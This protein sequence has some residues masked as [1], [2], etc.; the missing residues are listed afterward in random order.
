MKFGIRTP[1]LK[2]MIAARASPARIVRHTRG[3]TAP[4]G[5]G[6]LTNPKRAMYNRA[7]ERP[8]ASGPF[9]PHLQVSVLTAEG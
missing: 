1:W 4:R 3:V 5:L 2:K 6:W 9:L 7:T 8:S